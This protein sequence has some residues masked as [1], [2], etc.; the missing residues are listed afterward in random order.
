M[1]AILAEAFSLDRLFWK[2]RRRHWLANG[3]ATVTRVGYSGGAS[4]CLKR[5]FQ[6]QPQILF[7]TEQESPSD[8]NDLAR[9]GKV[10]VAPS[11]LDGTTVARCQR[12]PS[13]IV[14]PPQPRWKRLFRA[15]GVKWR[16]GSST[17]LLEKRRLPGRSVKNPLEMSSS[18]QH[19]CVSATGNLYGFDNAGAQV[20]SDAADGSL[21]GPNGRRLR[22]LCACVRADFGR[23][24]RSQC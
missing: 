23:Q 12:H 22:G 24:G 1:I 18:F 21:M 20:P 3:A 11:A 10:S 14:D 5:E 9:L 16:G 7:F 19:Q 15:T 8:A 6:G 2:N 13:P 4:G 17:D